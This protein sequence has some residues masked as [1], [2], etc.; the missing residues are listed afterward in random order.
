MSWWPG[1]S[2][3]SDR[4]AWQ[5]RHL[6]KPGTCVNGQQKAGKTDVSVAL[7]FRSKPFERESTHGRTDRAGVE[8]LNSAR[9]RTRSEELSGSAL[10]NYNVN[11]A[12]HETGHAS[13]ALTQYDNDTVPNFLIPFKTGE[14]GTVMGKEGDQN[15]LGQ[16]QL[17]FSEEDAAELAKHVNDLD[18]NP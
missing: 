6:F 15:V 17:E 11:V 9:V 7:R 4:W 8:V 12:A 1:W 16:D 13:G 14:A 5:L 3:E 18:D 10:V 2:E